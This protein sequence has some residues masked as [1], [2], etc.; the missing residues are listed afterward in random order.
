MEH[1]TFGRGGE[2][3][4]LSRKR[5]D[6]IVGYLSGEYMLYGFRMEEA[7][8]DVDTG[9]NHEAFVELSAS[10]SMSV[11]E[12]ARQAGVSKATAYRDVKYLCDAGIMVK[13]SVEQWRPNAT[14]FYYGLTK[15]GAVKARAFCMEQTKR[16]E[17]F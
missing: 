3:D 16:M 7:I 12:Y 8:M 14:K 6:R 9:R 13:R 5:Y 4:G 2:F 1:K 10:Y 17:D 11:A 15:Y